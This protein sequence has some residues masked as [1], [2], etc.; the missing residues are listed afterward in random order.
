MSN[1]SCEWYVVRWRALLA[2]VGPGVVF[3]LFC[4]AAYQKAFFLHKGMPC[5][6]ASIAFFFVGPLFPVR[7]RTRT[8]TT[9]RHR[10]R[11]TNLFFSLFHA[12]RTRIS[13][14][15]L[16]RS[17]IRCNF[18]SCSAPDRV[19]GGRGCWVGRSL[20]LRAPPRFPQ[21]LAIIGDP[22]IL[23]WHGSV[24]DDVAVLVSTDMFCT[25]HR[26]R[27]GS[28]LRTICSDSVGCSRTCEEVLMYRRL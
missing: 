14:S 16:Q 13:F 11:R 20:S 12:C 1:F 26:P 2:V 5:T 28:S 23:S 27:G 22:N 6:S 4:E 8:T 25:K 15:L 7:P 9:R 19:G 24:G 3:H 18:L 17:H 21:V 10:L